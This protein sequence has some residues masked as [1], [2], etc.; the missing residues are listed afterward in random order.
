MYGH[1]YHPDGPDGFRLE[2]CG[3][4]VS[5]NVEPLVK[6]PEAPAGAP[7][8]STTP[9]RSGADQGGNN[10]DSHPRHPPRVTR[11]DL[12][13]PKILR[14]AWIPVRLLPT[15]LQLQF[16]ALRQLDTEGDEMSKSG[17]LE[18]LAVGEEATGV[19]EKSESQTGK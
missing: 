14:K 16:W 2:D 11:I 5:V 17:L 15:L 1:R 3:H 10:Q 9:R 4:A 19:G 18:T 13:K 7:L 12:T 6:Q 8:A